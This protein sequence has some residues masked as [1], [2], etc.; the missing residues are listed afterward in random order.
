MSVSDYPYTRYLAAKK[1]VDDRALNKDVFER[2]RR[3]LASETSK[4]R[5]VLEVGAGLGTMAA[6]LI[7]WKLIPCADYL[8]LDIDGRLLADSHDWLAEWAKQRGLA[9]ETTGNRARIHHGDELD[10]TVQ[11]V[12]TELSSFLDENSRAVRADLLVANAFLDLVDVG[13]TLPAL[14]GLLAPNG[15]YWFTINFDGDTIFEPG[16]SYD[17]A[18][19]R[20]Y[21]RSMDE[22]ARRG[23]AAGDSR[24]GRHLFHH[25]KASGAR[26]LSAGASDWVVF[27]DHGKYEAD[28]A[29][30]ARHIIDTVDAELRQ[31][32][33]IDRRQLAE[34]VELR[35]AQ[36]DRGE[37]VY[38]AHQLDFCGRVPGLSR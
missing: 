18:L 36:I 20:V 6:R 7:E 10:W 38:V 3:E 13:A 2:L 26:I 11:L 35:H 8:L 24:A 33:E 12:E 9:F 15:L 4:R 31:H 37:L 14:F 28:E 34:W 5:V 23:R 25:L 22:R 21:H 30:F 17:D 32:A 16:H 29:Q 1:T 19:L 27:A